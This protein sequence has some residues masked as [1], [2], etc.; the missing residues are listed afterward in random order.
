MLISKGRPAPSEPWRILEVAYGQAPDVIAIRLDKE[1]KRIHEKGVEALVPFRRNSNGE[2]EWIVEH[3][4]VRGANGSLSLL[5]RTPGIECIRKEIA[6]PDWIAQL[7]AYEQPL[8]EPLQ[9]G[10]FVR[11][12]TGPCARMCGTISSFHSTTATVII[13]M[14]TKRVKVHTPEQN[15]QL[16]HCPPEHQSFFYSP[17]LFS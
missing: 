5:A 15:I 3:V 6:P 11:I 13:V 14:P 8:P 17:A 10:T 12:L 1:L 16:I 7:I 2:P 4:Y 9:I